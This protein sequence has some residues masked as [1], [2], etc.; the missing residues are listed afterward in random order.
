MKQIPD[1]LS[2]TGTVA[3]NLVGTPEAAAALDG[4]RLVVSPRRPRGFGDAAR[5]VAVVYQLGGNLRDLARYLGA[6]LK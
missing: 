5:A 1:R 6:H 3:G 2:P 4:R